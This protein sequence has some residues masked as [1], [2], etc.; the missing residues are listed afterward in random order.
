MYV[1]LVL[2]YFVVFFSSSGRILSFTVIYMYFIGKQVMAPK[3][4][5]SGLFVGLNRGHVV[6]KKELAPRPS[7]RKGVSCFVLYYTLIFKL[8]QTSTCLTLL[9][10]FRSGIK[11]VFVGSIK[12]S[13][14]NQ[15]GRDVPLVL[16]IFNLMFA[17][18]APLNMLP[19]LQIDSG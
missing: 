9:N 19:H 4:P 11:V 18:W 13:Y 1:L 14:L 15:L 5:N 6:T 17:E 2:V 10:S 8:V 3:Q 12:T 16:E 7:D